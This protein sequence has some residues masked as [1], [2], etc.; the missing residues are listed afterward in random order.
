MV[1]HFDTFTKTIYDLMPSPVAVIT[2]LHRGFG[3]LDY[4]KLSP[5]WPIVTT[6]K[7]FQVQKHVSCSNCNSVSPTMG[8]MPSSLGLHTC[9]SQ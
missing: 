9:L 5:T 1:V 7:A 6:N 2:V 3:Q 4:K 8:I